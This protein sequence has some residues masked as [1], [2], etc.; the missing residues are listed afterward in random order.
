ML[1]TQTK[2]LI[3]NNFGYSKTISDATT[4]LGT[5]AATGGSLSI[6]SSGYPSS[7]SVLFADSSADSGL[8]GLAPG[9]NTAE[10]DADNPV[11]PE[12]DR[13]WCGLT[14]T[15]GRTSVYSEFGGL[16][17]TQTYTNATEGDITVNC[18]YLIWRS[19]SYGRPYLLAHDKFENPV[20]LA[21]GES[22]TFQYTI[23]IG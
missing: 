16:L 6:S 7:A 18:V 5:S 21:P 12:D 15:A 14:C 1:M 9:A 20:V 3:L 23:G 13:A 4:A 8:F 11:V 10:P 17:I 2:T 22:I 19:A